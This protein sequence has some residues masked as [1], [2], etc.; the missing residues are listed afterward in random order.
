METVKC[1]RCGT[2]IQPGAVFCEDCLAD[3][4]QHPIA[5]GTPINLPNREKSQPAK[6]SKK[7]AHKPEEQ[8]SA[9]RRLVAWLI[10][11]TIVLTMALTAAIYLLFNQPDQNDGGWLPGQ[12]YGTSAEEN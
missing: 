6:R 10:A 9:L 11:L 12:N 3:M 5:P 2:E 7:R 8:I 1:M 4:Q